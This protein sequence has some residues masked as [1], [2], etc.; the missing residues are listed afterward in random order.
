MAWRDRSPAKCRTSVLA[1]PIRTRTGQIE[2]EP[3]SPSAQAT[4]ATSRFMVHSCVGNKTEDA[5]SH[6]LT[7]R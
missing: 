2:A 1:I 5:L 3:P 4:C 6:R 7:Y